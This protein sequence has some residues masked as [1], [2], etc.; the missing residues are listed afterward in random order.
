MEKKRKISVRKVLRTFVTTVT[1]AACVV[2][3]LGASQ[4]QETQSVRKVA[5]HIRNSQYRFLDKKDL[6][7]DLITKARIVEGQTRFSVLNV[8]AVEK[9]A[10]N[11]PWVS[12][13]E[14]YIDTKRDLHIYVT[15]RIP[16]ARIFYDNSLSCYIDSSGN[17]LPLSENYTFYTPVVTNV[18]MLADD[19]VNSELKKQIVALVKFVERD[20]FWSAQIAQISVTPDLKFE[21][22]PVLGTHKILFGDTAGMKGKFD[23][24]FAFYKNVLNRI[25]WDR[26]ELVD[27][28]FKD[29]IVASPA[30]PWEPSIKNPISNMD[31]VKSIIATAPTSLDPKPKKV[32]ASVEKNTTQ[33]ESKPK[34]KAAQTS[35][36]SS[37]ED[38]RNP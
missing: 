15:Q 13:A 35:Q 2:A 26:Y 28:R 29:Q 18:P 32:T 11:N 8:K 9:N 17:L 19:S 27:L 36:Y 33:P 16:I 6:W 12:E 37:E 5:L 25:G 31:W 7:R 1:T 14:A 21:L 10:L 20:T 34:K 24:L 22:I 38:L 4:I 30:V 23:N 3:V